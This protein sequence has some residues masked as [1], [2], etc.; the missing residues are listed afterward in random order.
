MNQEYPEA[1]FVP[2]HHF[3]EHYT[4]NATQ[5]KWHPRESGSFIGIVQCQSC[6]GWTFLFAPPPTHHTPGCTSFEDLRRL[7]DGSVAT[8]FKQAALGRGL[9]EDDAEWMAAMEEASLSGFPQQLRTLFVTIL[10]F[11]QPAQPAEILHRYCKS[12]SEDIAKDLAR[13]AAITCENVIWNQLLLSLD[14]LLR[15]HGK[16]LLDF[17]DMPHID[18]AYVDALLSSTDS[19]L[20][21]QAEKE[22]ADSNCKMLNDDQRRVYNAVMTAVSSGNGSVFFVDG[23]GGTGKTFL[24]N[25]ILYRIRS[26]NGGALAVASS[27]I[28]AE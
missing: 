10:L 24:Y 26:M 8:T 9:L 4:W 1:R 7:P 27:G 23:P 14:R 22:K 18:N 2:Y 20:L 25:T 5:G 17:P 21:P 19:G 3:P 13:S 15:D 16:S 12:L 28:A 11:C 6:R